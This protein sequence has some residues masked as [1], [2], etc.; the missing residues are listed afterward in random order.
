MFCVGSAHDP[1]LFLRS[2]LCF[3][4]QSQC[5]SQAVAEKK[6]SQKSEVLCANLQSLLDYLT[7]TK[8]THAMNRSLLLIE[9]MREPPRGGKVAKPEEFVRVY[10]ILLQ[11]TSPELF[12]YGWFSIMLLLSWK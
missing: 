9:T 2:F 7:H 6:R 5:G 4:Q 8:L 10:D 3:A 11:V 12:Y 1:L